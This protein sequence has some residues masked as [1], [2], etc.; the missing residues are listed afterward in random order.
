MAKFSGNLGYELPEHEIA[1]GVWMPAG[2][3]EHHARGDILSQSKNYSTNQSSTND[4]FSLSNRISIVLDRFTA[5]HY[6]E[7]KYICLDG[8]RWKVSSIEINRPRLILTLGGIYNGD[9]PD[10]E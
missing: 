2:V 6:G 8:L 3:T 5:Q 10:G 9:V 7:L 4:D 1:P